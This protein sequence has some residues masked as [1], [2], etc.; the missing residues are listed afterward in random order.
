MK[1]PSILVIV[2]A[3]LGLSIV[4]DNA[5][6]WDVRGNFGTEFRQFPNAPQYSPFIKSNVS[7]SSEVELFKPIGEAG[8]FTITPFVRIDQQDGERTHIDFREFLYTYTSESWEI[9][10]GLGKEFWGVAESQNIV[11]VINQSDQV[12]GTSKAAKLGQPMIN[13]KLLKDWGTVDVFV[14]PG[15][16]ERTFPGRDGR[17][18]PP[19]IIDTD[20]ALYESSAKNNHVDLALRY[21]HS[22]DEWDFGVHLF[23]GT[24]RDPLLQFN[25][26][27][28]TL[29][30]FY[31]QASQVGIDAQATLESWLLKAEAIY[32]SGDAIEDHAEI[33][34]GV[35]YSFYGIAESDTDLG[36]V[37]EW[38]FDA[39]D[40]AQPFQNDLLLG[41][42]VAL[43][44]ESSSEALLG[45]IQDLDHGSQTFSLT[46]STRIGNNVKLSADINIWHN[47]DDDPQFGAFADEDYLQLDLRYFF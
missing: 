29:S 2:F 35:E 45:V 14:L 13:L 3:T 10:A 24:A 21:S 25:Q 44:N 34:S 15:F 18:R 22:I 1:H 5:L 19:L 26:S 20:N 9:R 31:Y 37:A 12:E 32:K 41:L 23:H 8:S 16:R 7:V 33:V 27:N 17:P 47:V 4:T 46:A 42:R 30:P 43:N 38:L 36:I 28:S 40:D 11:D 6:A 39:R